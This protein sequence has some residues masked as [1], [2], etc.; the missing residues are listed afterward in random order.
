MD[1]SRM[2]LNKNSLFHNQPKSDILFF[3][4]IL[5]KR[6]VRS[7]VKL[8]PFGELCYRENLKLSFGTDRT[9]RNNHSDDLVADWTI[10]A[11]HC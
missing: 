5:D 1:S 2:F 8:G 6:I 7:S 4:D 9:I 11:E 10:T 3:I